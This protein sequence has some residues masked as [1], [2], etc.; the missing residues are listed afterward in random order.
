M[1]VSLKPGLSAVWVVKG[2]TIA[3]NRERKPRPRRDRSIKLTL[4]QCIRRLCE[5]T[6]SPDD[7][8][9]IGDA[10]TG[11]RVLKLSLTQTTLMVALH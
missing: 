11:K 4:D 9:S 6:L 10:L 8:Y 7:W 1:A 5:L 2:R 3:R